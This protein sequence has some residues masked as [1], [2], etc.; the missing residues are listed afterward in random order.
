M[1]SNWRNRP[2]TIDEVNKNDVDVI[3]SIDE[4]GSPSIKPALKAV[5]TG[6]PLNISEKHFTVTACTIN[7]SDFERARDMV[8]DLKHKYWSN[9][10]FTYKGREKRVCFHSREIRTKREAFNPDI[11]DYDSF[12]T[13]LSNLISNIP[14]KIYASHINKEAHVAKYIFPASPYDLC[15]TFVLERILLDMDKGKRCI[16]ILE[17]RGK[18]EDL[19]LLNFIKKLIDRGSAYESAEVFSQIK[20]VYFNP[21]WCKSADDKMSYWELELA[22]LCAYPIQKYFVYGTRDPAFNIIY[23]KLSHYPTPRGK[24]LKS[25]P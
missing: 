18:K 11:I 2:T 24:G 12:I 16:V 20:G 21:K 13:D 15:M 9:A 10:L 25:F 8:M 3:I 7:M 22:D 5:D 4:S 6:V 17:S 14:A 19:A 1:N 23:K